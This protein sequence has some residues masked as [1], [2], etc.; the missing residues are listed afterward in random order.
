MQ[1]A[2][3]RARRRVP[4]PLPLMAGAGLSA[5]AAL[6]PALAGAQ[7]TD[8]ARPSAAVLQ[9]LIETQDAFTA[10]AE[11]VTPSVVSIQVER[12]ARDA[13]TG[14]AAYQRAGSGSGFIVSRDG[15][16]LTN[17]HV[18]AGANR[19]RVT[20]LDKRVFTARIVGRDPST[21]VA[22]I[23]I[24]GTDLPVATLGDDERAKVGQW[25]LAIGN[26]LGLDFSVTSGIVSAKG[27]NIPG[28]NRSLY[29]ITDFIQTDAAINPGNSG[30]PLVNIR[31]EVV[32]INSAILTPTGM[33]AGY[34]FAIPISLAREVMDD[35]VKYGE[36]RRGVLGVT[37]SEVSAPD[38]E[39]LGLRSI[40]GA[41]VQSFSG[42]E[43]PALA[44]GMREEDVIVA[45]DG[46]AVDRVGTLQRIVRAREPGD[47]VEL[48]V[49]RGGRQ[50][51]AR[52]RLAEAP[53]EAQ[54]AS[55]EW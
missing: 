44:A 15:Y 1:N 17:N 30:G 42:R 39:R 50:V 51:S 33:S 16:I 28:L 26:P 38:A 18:V 5:L 46:K 24:D 3:A 36:V 21:D 10:V 8:R 45:A 29:A 7:S 41:L 49:L 54:V 11:Q 9:P 53:P 12:L 22:V 55:G 47:V 48:T 4:L 14:G 23:R 52:V 13:R 31:G 20:L 37:L 34:G 35:L 19:V 2:R 40:K 6:A 43:S 25:V 27:R 32:G